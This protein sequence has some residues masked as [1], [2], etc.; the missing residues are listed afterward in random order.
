MLPPPQ[1]APIRKLGHNKQSD[2]DSEETLNP[3]LLS[4]CLLKHSPSF[5]G[6][7]HLGPDQVRVNGFFFG[8]GGTELQGQRLAG[9]PRQCGQPLDGT[10]CLQSKV[11]TV[12]LGQGLFN[13]SHPELLPL[14]LRG[15]REKDARGENVCILMERRKR[16]HFEDFNEVRHTLE[17]L[18]VPP[19]ITR[20]SS[21]LIKAMQTL[22]QCLLLELEVKSVTYLPENQYEAA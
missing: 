2:D 21:A 6:A 11:G 4:D 12:Q 3:P 13:Q 9:R 18:K 19:P 16:C 7:Q 1:D 14:G 22:I 15:Q 8:V 10:T 5:F 20:Q 17:I